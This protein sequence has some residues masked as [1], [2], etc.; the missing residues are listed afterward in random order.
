[1]E[2]LERPSPIA[3]RDRRRGWSL[4]FLC[5]V[6]PVALLLLEEAVRQQERSMTI[7]MGGADLAALVTAFSSSVRSAGRWQACWPR[8]W[9]SP[10]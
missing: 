5:L 6:L 10:P 9:V 8:T 7:G 2:R 1:M 3:Y 4:L